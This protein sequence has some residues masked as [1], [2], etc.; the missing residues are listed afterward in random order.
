M[1]SHDILQVKMLR[2]N[3]SATSLSMKQF[4]MR[5]DNHRWI[6]ELE[7]GIELSID[8]IVRCSLVAENL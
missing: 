8:I 1:N 4:L 7:L 6:M 5:H 2:E 3:L